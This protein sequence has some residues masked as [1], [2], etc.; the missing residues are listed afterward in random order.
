[1]AAISFLGE[2]PL[3]KAKV[4]LLLSREAHRWEQMVEVHKKH[5]FFFVRNVFFLSCCTNGP[6]EC[7]IVVRLL[8]SLNHCRHTKCAQWIHNVLECDRLR[9]L[10]MGNCCIVVTLLWS[11]NL[12]HP[13]LPNQ[14]TTSVCNTCPVSKAPRHKR[15][16]PWWMCCSE[17]SEGVWPSKFTF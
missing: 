13:P 3:Q 2:G 10:Q 17:A 15:L 7:C 11:L 6:L 8:S 14:P 16:K 1:M 9:V 12:R 5:F 4:K